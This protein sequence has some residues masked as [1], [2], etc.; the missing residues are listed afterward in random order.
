MDVAI[1]LV[2]CIVT[3]PIQC[4]IAILVYK[5][6]GRPVLFR[7]A[8]P[9]K[10]GKIF[11]LLKFRS[12]KPPLPGSPVPADATR[13]TSF[14]RAL[15]A[16]SLDE[17][18]SLWNVVKGDMSLVGPRPLLPQYLE[19]YTPE[20]NRRHEVRPG[21]TGLAQVTG[22]NGIGWDEKF[23]L[24]VKYV[25]SRSLGLDL[26]ILA[27]TVLKV[28]QRDGISQPGMA[29]MSEFMGNLTPGGGSSP[30]EENESNPSST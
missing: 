21:I 10:D 4:V 30:I 25:D 23:Q 8:R 19:R 9:G 6:L 16:S 7:Q 1:A 2:A 11:M 15:R 18:P 5:N 13:L 24:D 22:R 12:M 26:R 29:T 14:G 20:Q 28:V 17:L 27:G 3:L